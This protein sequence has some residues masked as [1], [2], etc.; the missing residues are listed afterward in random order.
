MAFRPAKL[1]VWLVFA[2]LSGVRHPAFS[3]STVT[4]KA[5][6]NL[7]QSVEMLI[8]PPEEEAARFFKL[9][10]RSPDSLLAQAESYLV[11]YKNDSAVVISN[12]IC[13]ALKGQDQLQ[14][15]IGL[16]AQLVLARA[17]QHNDAD[18]ISLRLLLHVKESCQS[19]GPW[20]TY[21][22][23]CLALALL[24]ESRKHPTQCL[25]HLIHAKSALDRNH[26]NALYPAYAMRACSYYRV[27]VNNQDS[28]VYYAK[29]V[30]RTAP[31]YNLILEEAWGNLL[32]AYTLYRNDSAKW[33]EHLQAAAKLFVKIQDYTGLSYALRGI[34]ATYTREGDLFRALVFNDST[35]LAAQKSIVQ[36]NKW[37]PALIDAYRLRANLF[38]QMERHDSAW[39]YLKKSY[40]VELNFVQAKESA[41]VVEIDARYLNQQKTKQIQSQAEAIHVEKMVKKLLLVI[42][43]ITL[44]LAAGLAAGLV[45]HIKG[46]RQLAE[47]NNLIQQQAEQLQSLDAAK[48]RFFANISHELRTPLTLLTSPIQTLLKEN[49]WTEKQTQLLKMAERSGNL[50]SRLIN[51]ILDL[52]KLEMG[53]MTLA[54]KPTELRSWFQA[55]FAQFESLAVQKQIDYKVFLNIAEREI[56]DLD[57]EK[58]R[59]IVFNLLS[60]AFKFTP[61]GGRIEGQVQVS[62]QGLQLQISNSGPGIHPDDLP[63][64]FDQYFQSNRP[65]K[66]AEG[67]TGIGLALCREYAQ[68]FGGAISVESAPG[69]NTVFRVTFPLHRSLA[70]TEKQ[71]QLALQMHTAAPEAEVATAVL[72]AELPKSAAKQ[73][74]ILLVEDNPDLR[75]YISLVLQDKY[76]VIAT[77]HGQ[78]A[79]SVIH[80]KPGWMNENSPEKPFITPDLILT[81]LMMP[82][83]DGYQLLEKLKSDDAT[84]HIPVIMLTARAEA[85]DKLQ[86]LRI[87]VDDYLTK[88]FDE[89]ELLARIA[90]LLKNK[91]ARLSETI[92]GAS[93]ENPGLSLSA[94]DQVW[95]E[96]FEK[97][98]QEKLDSD[99]LTVP[100]LARH[101][102]MSESTLLRQ[103][104]RLTGLSP[105]QYL[106][107]IRLAKARFFLENR[108]YDSIAKVASQVGYSDVRNFSRSFKER[109]GKLP[110]HYLGD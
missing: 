27:L 58:C 19:N 77:E 43:G 45:K 81:D 11:S 57:R 85:Q 28:A 20:D 30:L 87:G 86:A 103:L 108:S 35:I 80:G 95:L 46:M 10:E 82:V 66:P 96:D 78:A 62:I 83:M 53:K 93:T 84:R 70:K 72:E 51:E 74:T 107:E 5:F 17:L 105:V 64:I 31:S 6:N 26:L 92:P 21:V 23:S 14:S 98:V 34:A 44:L 55:Y 25:G 75:N 65:D 12:L 36:G 109:F 97:Y 41:K 29:E 48:S 8:G 106:Q 50:L 67:G 18:S 73:A 15:P 89:E 7:W 88:P 91:A 13:H 90:N 4:N 71:D 99:L 94:P 37:N 76:M 33:L 49:Q 63:H 56:A 47:K 54:T 69:V 79:L 32:L 100:E 68:L 39:H 38:R 24:E 52:R 42:F 9:K 110:S 2:F 40:E 61:Q 60:N 101:F 1:V 22:K 3:Q 102:L 104:K 59:Q 16:K